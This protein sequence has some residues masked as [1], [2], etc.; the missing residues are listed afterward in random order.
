M[1]QD[2]RFAVR[3]QAAATLALM[4]FWGWYCYY[5]T[6]LLADCFC[7][8]MEDKLMSIMVYGF[9]LHMERK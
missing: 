3:V 1:V 4:S 9:T 5:L 6:K 2:I 7:K 8:K